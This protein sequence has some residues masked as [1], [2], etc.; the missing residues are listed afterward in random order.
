VSGANTELLVRMAEALGELR[1]RMAFAG[2]CATSLLI[3]D[4]AAARRRGPR[5]CWSG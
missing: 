1:E 3:T 5:C 2:G 4:P